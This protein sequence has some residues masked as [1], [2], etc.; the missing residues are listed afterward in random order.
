MT[1]HAY[2]LV[3]LTLEAPLST[4]IDGYDRRPVVVEIPVA[5]GIQLRPLNPFQVKGVYDK[6]KRHEDFGVLGTFLERTLC[7]L[8]IDDSEWGEY[9]DNYQSKDLREKKKSV[10]EV[11]MVI[12]I[13]LRLRGLCHFITPAGIHG[14]SFNKLRKAKNNSIDVTFYPSQAIPFASI[15]PIEP[16]LMSMDDIEWVCMHVQDLMDI[17]YSKKIDLTPTFI[18]PL[19][20]I[21]APNPNV[22]LVMTWTAIEAI[23]K[24]KEGKG[25]GKRHSIKSRVSKMLFDTPKD[26]KKQYDKISKLYDIRSEVVHGKDRLSTLELQQQNYHLLM[27]SFDL[28]RRLQTSIVENKHV[29][30]DDELHEMQQNYERLCPKK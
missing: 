17:M 30:N 11:A 5:P 21:Y 14:S 27:E 10:E 7:E 4:I 15:P 16:R 24:P 22:Q 12:L 8:V 13:L 3:S 23:T 2:P 19:N 9:F 20:A 28:L 25:F 18:D 29:P 6:F 26:M 1:V